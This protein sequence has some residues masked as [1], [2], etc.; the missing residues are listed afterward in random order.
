MDIGYVISDS[1]KYPSTNWKNVIILGLLFMFSFLIVPLFLLYGYVFRVIKASLAGIE[2]LPDF[3][4]WGEMLVDGIKLFLVH[5][6][7]MLPAMILVIYSFLALSM[8]LHSFSYINP[9]T[10]LNLATVYSL[11]GGSIALGFG[12]AIIYSLIIYPIMAVGIGNMAFH[13][14]DLGS[15]FKIGDLLA[16]ISEIG[17]VDLIIWYVAIIII[18]ITIFVAGTIIAMIPLLGWLLIT[19]IVYPYLYIFFGR[20]LAWLYASAFTEEYEP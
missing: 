20:A 17:W 4:E 5:I 9:A 3:E 16:I 2:D 12:S 14:G 13:N 11:I 8:A 15:A 18:S 19:L 7:Y 1:M 6:I 10:T